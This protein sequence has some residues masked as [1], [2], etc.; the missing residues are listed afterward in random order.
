MVADDVFARH[1]TLG[2]RDNPKGSV[3]LHH[4]GVYD[5]KKT[6][7]AIHILLALQHS[8]LISVSFSKKQGFKF[9][10]NVAVAI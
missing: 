3:G 8:A 7:A 1:V 10:R 5:R 2:E 9:S 6:V 4:A